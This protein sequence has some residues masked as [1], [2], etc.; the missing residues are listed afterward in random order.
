MKTLY[1]NIR[2]LVHTENQPKSFL[3][4]KEMAAIQSI[5]DAFLEIENGCISRFGTMSELKPHDFNNLAEIHNLEGQLVM[6]AFADSHT[7][8]VYAKTREN[9]FVDRIKGLTYA[10]IA[11][12]GGGILNSA[13]RLGEMDEE[14]LFDDAWL[15]LEKMYRRGTA[16]VEIKSGYGLTPESEWKILRVIRRLKEK[17]DLNIKATFLGAHAIPQH[18]KQNREAYLQEIVEVMLPK[19]ADECLADY[20]DIFC[21][22]NYFTVEEMELI[23]EAG[24]KYNLIPKVH[25]NQFTAIGGIR[26]AIEHQALS[27][28]HLEIMPDEDIELLHGTKCM[29]TAL[30]SC[31]FFLNIPYAPGRKMIDS[32]LPLA[33]ASDL[34][35][36]TTPSG[37][38]EFVWSLACTQMK[39]LP[40]EALVALTHN[41]AYAMGLEKIQGSIAVGKEANLIITDKIENLSILPYHFGESHIQK[42]LIKGTEPQF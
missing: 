15:R 5:D 10:E 6:P 3:A 20:I 27:V 21:E 8:T 26:K 33:L 16:A 24:S 38:L 31:S 35:P 2:S 1:T 11:A 4:G 28:D 30:P 29:P 36:G 42:V 25:V 7:H 19:I 9:E 37:N 13:R 41:S 32:G 34:N 14:Q 39:L 22:T 17:S 40:E 23:L 12:K 18:Y